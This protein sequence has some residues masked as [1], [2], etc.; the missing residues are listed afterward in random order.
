MFRSGKKAFFSKAFGGKKQESNRFWR[1]IH[2]EKREF[3][4]AAR[5]NRLFYPK[6]FPGAKPCT[7]VDCRV[8]HSLH[9]PYDY[10][11]KNISCH[12]VSERMIPCCLP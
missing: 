11:E 3:F 12:A 10:D 5:K 7:A 4:T 8:I 6:V 9:T 2:R 1:N